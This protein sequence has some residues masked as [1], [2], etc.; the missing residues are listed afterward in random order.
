MWCRAIPALWALPLSL[1]C[2]RGTENEGEVSKR[3][4]QR[5]SAEPTD[6]AGQARDRIPLE[7]R[8]DLN[9]FL[10]SRALTLEKVHAEAESL[11]LLSSHERDGDSRLF[12]ALVLD[13]G[14]VADV[15]TSKW[16]PSYLGIPVAKWVNFGPTESRGLALTFDSRAEGYVGTTAWTWRGRDFSISYEDEGQSCTS[17]SVADLDADGLSELV[18]YQDAWSSSLC[19]NE[20]A[21]SVA[22]SVPTGLAWPEPLRWSG[23]GWE[24][25]RG[26]PRAYWLQRAA[27]FDSA[28]RFI[29]SDADPACKPHSPVI[30]SKIR[31]W[32]RRALQAAGSK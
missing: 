16:Y 2:A 3:P 20:C 17:A 14:R 29:E 10:E 18:V 23:S 4:K 28:A 5:D 13:R 30:S 22:E 11:V 25:K 27:A 19:D 1:C 7:Q 15:L 12:L 21:L 9:A 6:T 32:N 8:V 31:E 26:I 24:P